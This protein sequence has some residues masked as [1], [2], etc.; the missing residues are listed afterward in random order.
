MII[1]NT[2]NYYSFSQ[3]FL[4]NGSPPR[5]SVISNTLQHLHLRPPRP[6]HNVNIITYAD[7]ITVYSSDIKYNK[8]QQKIQ[9]YLE[10]IY[11]W[12]I[13]NNL[14]LDPTKT[15]TTLFTPDPKEYKINLFI[16]INNQL[17]P[18]ERNPKILGLSLDPKLT[19]NQHN[20]TIIPP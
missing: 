1:I 8:A 19:F 16:K 12:T 11:N 7:D 14:Q 6:P 9:P 3:Q 10:H 2:S 20:S 18:T 4:Q 13:N 5:R 17:L 15:M